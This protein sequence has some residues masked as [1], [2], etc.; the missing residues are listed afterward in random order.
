[1]E[2]DRQVKTPK[3]KN[4]SEYDDE[5]GAYGDEEEEPGAPADDYY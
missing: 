4:D 3:A 2:F 1:M 5:Y